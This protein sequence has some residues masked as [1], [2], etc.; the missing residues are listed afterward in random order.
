[1]LLEEALKDLR[2]PSA[3]KAL[4][5]NAVEGYNIAVK[6]IMANRKMTVLNL[7]SALTI[8]MLPLEPGSTI[9]AGQLLAATSPDLFI[10]TADTL[11]NLEL[12]DQALR[13]YDRAIGGLTDKKTLAGAWND[14]GV[15]LMRLN[16]NDEAA[17]CFQEALH[18]DPSL[19][20]ARVNLGEC[21]RA[22]S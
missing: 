4:E 7:E 12:F 18:N 8:M 10:R 13:E 21:T 16:R 5:L 6:I 9:K 19:D 3:Q 14:K 15:C 2:D 22:K 11:A 1:M 20:Q 17:K